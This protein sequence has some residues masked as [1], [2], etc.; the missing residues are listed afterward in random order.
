[1][2]MDGPISLSGHTTI[3][4]AQPSKEERLLFW[5][6]TTDISRLS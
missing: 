4:L 1:M 5:V 2:E 6:K 3:L